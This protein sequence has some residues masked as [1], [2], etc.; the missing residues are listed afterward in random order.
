[1]V[2]GRALPCATMT[3]RRSSRLYWLIGR[4]GTNRLISRIHPPVYRLFGGRGFLGRSFGMRN[5]IVTTVG[6]RTGRVREIPLFA[7]E[8]G[9]RLVLIGSYAGRDQEPA[10]VGNLL[11]HPAT[12]VRMGRAEVPMRARAAE[13]EE[14]ERLWAL[15][16][17][18]Y[19]GYEDYQRWTSRRIPV[20]VL[21]PADAPDAST[22]ADPAA[23]A[24]AEVDRDDAATEEGAA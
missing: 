13:G 2:R 22:A 19:P 15:A 23:A 18:A 20:I 6:R 12:S 1:M 24:E 16:V 3:T 11:A 8:V 4:F 10:W 14:R 7:T 9:E 21:E 5:V 17:R